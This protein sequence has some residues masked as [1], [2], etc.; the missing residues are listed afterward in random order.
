M[1]RAR[2]R[3]QFFEAE[4]ERNLCGFEIRR[5]EQAARGVLAHLIEKL[6]IARARIA[7]A[8][9]QRSR[10]YAQLLRDAL[11]ARP[12]TAHA[13]ADGFAR[14]LD[15]RRVTRA[16]GQRGFESRHEQLEQLGIVCL[17]W[18]IERGGRE[19]QQIGGRVEK[20]LAAEVTPQHRRVLR[21]ARQLDPPRRDAL[22]GAAHI[23]HD[24]RGER[25][26][27]EQRW[28]NWSTRDIPAQAGRRVVITGATGGL[29]YETALALARAG[30]V[31][32]LTG[33]NAEKGRAA[34]QA[35]R[36]QVPAADVRYAQLDLASL[37]SV[38][39]FVVAFA[40]ENEGLDVLINNAG[41]MSPPTRHETADGFELQF[42]TNYLSHF[43]LTAQLLPLLRR[44]TAP[45][46][47]NVSS[48]AHR[49]GAIRFEDLNWQKQYRAWA[50]YGQSKLAMLMFAFELQRRS[51]AHRWGLMSN[52]AHPGYA[53]TGLQAAGPQLGTNGRVP[54]RVRVGNLLAP[55]L[56]QSAADG[57][58]PTL[59]A[60][61]SPEAK[62]C[63][64]Y[65]PD[66]FYELKGPVTSAFVA[67][68]AK[69][70][71]VAARLW[72][73]SEE[74]TQVSWPQATPVGVRT[75]V[76]VGFTA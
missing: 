17:K 60:A 41:V 12:L 13:A 4:Q 75:P 54:L 23:Q 28:S 65:G 37:W 55:L 29:G 27:G 39:Q 15:P 31:V 46:V 33:R 10:T 68:Q 64:Y 19:H 38:A 20:N 6:L 47:V 58:L 16:P 62:A 30:A 14:S 1:K 69:D 44:G 2:E 32:T 66:G 11:D 5:G 35:I 72:D 9:L 45:R 51:D 49:G 53:V 24:G 34:L 22:A 74:M 18:S 40:A 67:P 3:I 56:A 36:A 52:A 7:E 57:A 25:A 50:S 21:T 71:K 26:V 43:A 73:V 63:G 59:F 42:G 61:T 76:E 8:T 70:A 48:L